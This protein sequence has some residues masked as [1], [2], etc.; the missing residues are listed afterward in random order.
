M[1]T[2]KDIKFRVG[3]KKSTIPSEK[4]GDLITRQEVQS[5]I[6]T[7]I[8]EYRQE[9]AKQDEDWK[10][11]EDMSEDYE[12]YDEEEGTPE[13]EAEE[14]PEEETEEEDMKKNPMDMMKNALKKKI[15]K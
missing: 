6:D 1:F 3:P 2:P 8:E 14:T 7:A 11:E 4:D 12:G 15:K 10:K 5:M 13:E 9:D